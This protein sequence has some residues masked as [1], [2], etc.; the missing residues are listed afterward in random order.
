M[1]GAVVAEEA[2]EVGRGL[3]CRAW[4]CVLENVGFSWQDMGY[5]LS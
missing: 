2:D 1:C 5:S 4:S 3:M